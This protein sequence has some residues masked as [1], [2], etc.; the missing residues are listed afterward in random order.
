[1]TRFARR[2][3]TALAGFAV[4]ALAATA[5]CAGGDTDTAAKSSGD[6]ATRTIKNTLN[7][8]VKDVPTKPKRVLA[9]W[10]T[11]SELADLGVRPVASLE[12]EFLETE[13]GADTFK[14]FKNIPT[15]GSFEG[16]DVEKALNA[17]PDLIVGMDN[18][19]LE[20]DYDELSDIAPT[21][22]FKIAEPTDVWDNYPKIAD[23]VGQAT[24]YKE[25]NAG[26]DKKLAAVA[27]Q[28]G[29][30]TKSAK[31]VSINT[32]GNQLFIDTSKSL[33]WRRIDAA[34]F[35]YLDRYAKNPKRYVEETS[36]EK[37][38]D[39]AGADVIFYETDLNGTIEPGAKSLIESASFKR[40]PAAE[41]GHVYPVASGT[42]YTFP[43]GDAQ[44]KDLAAAAKDYAGTS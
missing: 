17:K 40:L 19:G 23:T 11:G 15:V 8:D 35:G 18:G 39:L 10:R 1:M 42:I 13:L 38:P 6:G 27:K 41:A 9:L 5:G 22:I 25:R 7:G 37:L 28:H 3:R 24:R 30:K 2:M 33:T 20:I 16:V 4:L 32:T 29:A 36:R 14:K 26:L 21:V 12:G 31:A 44:A 43:G 34:G